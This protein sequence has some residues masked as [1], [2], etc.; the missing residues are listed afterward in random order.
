MIKELQ[1][2]GDST[3]TKRARYTY[4]IHTYTYTEMMH[5]AYT[6]YTH[7]GFSLLL[8]IAFLPS[9]FRFPLRVRSTVTE[10]QFF[11]AKSRPFCALAISY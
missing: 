9:F 2:S 1:E 10:L 11:P 6:G 7:N 3:N 8:V 5:D 4:T